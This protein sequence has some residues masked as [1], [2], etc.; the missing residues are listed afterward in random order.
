MIFCRRSG[1]HL[2]VEIGWMSITP[3]KNLWFDLDRIFLALRHTANLLDDIWRERQ[4][5]CGVSLWFSI[6]S[7][8]NSATVY[9]KFFFTFRRYWSTYRW[10]LIL[11][12]RF[13]ITFNVLISFK[14]RPQ[15]LYAC[16]WLLKPNWFSIEIF[17]LFIPKYVS[18]YYR[19][20]RWRQIDNK[21]LGQCII[22]DDIL[23]SNKKWR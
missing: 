12:T 20:W 3:K 7:E 4:W 10:R 18:K 5:L 16:D 13:N 21:P 9:V 11:Q 15:K 1:M 14:I 19:E 22:S 8:L 6:C 2:L 23:F 17:P